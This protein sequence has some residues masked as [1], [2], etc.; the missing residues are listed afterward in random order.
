MNCPHCQNPLKL[1]QLDRFKNA[2]QYNCKC[3][4]LKG[5]HSYRVTFYKD[6]LTQVDII[7]K[8]GEEFYHLGV[9]PINNA[10]FLD[11]LSPP[12]TELSCWHPD[13]KKMLDFQFCPPFDLEHPLE[14]AHK[15]AKSLLSLKPFY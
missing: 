3:L 2:N 14:S 11:R 4:D 15:I 7:M 8:L 10:T 5:F 12:T 9:A 6:E 1:E 13:A